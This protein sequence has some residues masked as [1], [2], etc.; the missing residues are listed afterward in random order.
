VKDRTC[1]LHIWRDGKTRSTVEAHIFNHDLVGNLKSTI[2][3]DQVRT[4]FLSI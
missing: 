1:N 3:L 4:Y 2:T